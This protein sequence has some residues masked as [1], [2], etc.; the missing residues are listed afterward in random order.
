MN[1]RA[2]R[3]IVRKDLRV[4]LQNKGVTLPMII[5]PLII[6][7]VLPAIVAFLPALAGS[8]AMP[9]DD[10]ELLYRQV[11]PSV[12]AS[13]EGY[14]DMQRMVVILLLYFFAPLYLILPLMVSSV[15]AADSFAGE[16]ERGTLEAL[17][18]TPTTDA[19]LYLGKALAAWLPA[20]AVS[21]IGFV[22]YGLVANLAAWPL[23]GRLFF[24]NLTWVLLAAW[25]APAAAG[26]GLGTMVLVSSR[27]QGF[28]DAYQIGG[29]IVLPV[30][31]LVLAQA[32][33]VLFFS[34]ALTLALGL[35]FWAVDIVL[36]WVGA[37]LFRRSEVLARR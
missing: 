27:A 16:K 31:L 15:I 23:L 30:V 14:S 2:L 20:L 33:G 36:L 35:I 25:V 34:L 1:A 32:A 8:S 5:V 24:P 28:Q 9:T 12:R 18:H 7:V 3:A 10:L 21:W 29:V 11:P 22:A 19:E 6:L 37:R 13:L 26:L 4:V 17:L